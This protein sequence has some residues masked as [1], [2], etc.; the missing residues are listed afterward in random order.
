MM[1]TKKEH[2]TDRD[3]LL[4]PDLWPKWPVCP[5]VNRKPEA[6]VTTGLVF[7]DPTKMD[8][9]WHVWFVPGGNIWHMDDETIK[10]GSYEPLDALL[11]AGW[12]VD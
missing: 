9:T 8:Y 3:W 10:K 7:G 1:A 6:K 12:E 4:Q 2:L 11:A 5:L